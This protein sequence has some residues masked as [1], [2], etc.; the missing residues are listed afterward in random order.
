MSVRKY[1]ALLLVFAAFQGFTQQKVQFAQYQQAP[2]L[3]NPAF[4]G[5]EDFID[6]KVGYRN[7]WVGVDNSP[8]TAF[9][10][11]NL[12]FKISMSSEYKRKGIRLIE[13]E[14]YHKLETSEEFQWRKARRQGFAGW[15]IQNE[16]GA[17]SEI[18][19]FLGY[20]YH[21][22][23]SDYIIW[24][25]GASAGVVNSNLDASNLTVTNP[26]VDPT[27]LAYLKD[28]GASTDAIINLG[29]V[30]YSRDWY[31]G[32][33]ANK[34]VVSNISNVNNYGSLDNEMVHNFMI[35]LTY[36]PERYG[37]LIIPGAMVEYSA[38]MPVMFTLN[39]RLRYEDAMWGGIGYRND[40]S[41]YLSFGL[42]IT[43]NIALNYA[44]EYSFSDFTGVNASTHEI[45]LGFK[46]NNRNFSRAYM[47]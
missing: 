8:S 34:V 46:L 13:P 23:L 27:Y 40:D 35:G 11:A 10:I 37:Y 6:L 31:V 3:Y 47:W 38:N 4:S 1:I 41:I 39:V 44:F 21:L 20:A 33:A 5:I 43:Q 19:G 22:P 7:R 17:V 12:A 28:G 25:V 45:T 2:V 42:Y 36:K 9:V 24:S 18:G 16:N 26:D 14:A 29:T 15:I 30:L 32:Y